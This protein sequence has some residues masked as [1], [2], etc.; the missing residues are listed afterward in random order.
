MPRRL[1]NKNKAKFV[2][3]CFFIQLATVLLVVPTDG[4]VCHRS[5]VRVYFQVMFPT[6][7][8]KSIF[9]WTLSFRYVTC[10]CY[11]TKDTTFPAKVCALV[12]TLHRTHTHTHNKQQQNDKDAAQSSA[13]SAFNHRVMVW[14]CSHLSSEEIC[15]FVVRF[16][17]LTGQ[18]FRCTYQGVPQRAHKGIS[19]LI[20][21]NLISLRRVAR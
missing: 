10:G 3:F 7:M 6:R 14:V 19:Y 8:M 17:I 5:A 12:F 1:D 21:I 13:R 4:P 2:L 16:R 9:E 15:G 18:L 20:I 11:G